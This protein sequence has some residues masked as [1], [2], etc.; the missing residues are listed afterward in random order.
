MKQLILMAIALTGLCTA[1]IK[2]K[3]FGTLPRIE[4]GST[5]D[6]LAGL[7][8]WVEQIA[9]GKRDSMRRVDSLAAANHSVDT[10]SLFHKKNMMV[11]IVEVNDHAFANV[12]CFVDANGK[13]MF[14]LAFPF[15]AN[16]N[17]NPNTGKAYVSYNPEHQAMLRLG[18]FTAVMRKGVPVGLSLLGNHDDAGFSNFTSLEDA[19]D[20][21]QLVAIEVRKLGFSAV[22][23]D[24]EYSNYVTDADPHSYLMFM[25]ELK[26]LLPD[27]YLCY[28]MTGGG[29]G[30]YNGKQMGDIADAL[31]TIFYPQ[32]PGNRPYGAPNSKT[33]A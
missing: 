5:T 2:E 33:F 19:R 15:S 30:T 14:D 21:A 25:L 28:Y 17:I 12:N 6:S 16:L 26:R 31:F 10:N 18:T 13:P 23:T 11:A 8:A 20:F 29:N 7:R 4:D 27:I 32:Y 22:L 3:R 24:D 9:A 1:C